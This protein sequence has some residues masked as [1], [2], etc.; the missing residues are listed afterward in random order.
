MTYEVTYILKPEL[1]N[2][3]QEDVNSSI[4][5]IIADLGGESQPAERAFSVDIGG[6]DEQNLRKFAYPIGNYRQGFYYAMQFDAPGEQLNTLEERLK[7]DSRILRHLVVSEF[8][9]VDELVQL[10]ERR[11][12]NMQEMEETDNQQSFKREV[13]KRG[14]EVGANKSQSQSE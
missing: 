8:T 3:E 2:E 4:Q 5:Q 6:T 11:H 7:K 1:T 13:N 12:Q 10:T 14:E 9:P